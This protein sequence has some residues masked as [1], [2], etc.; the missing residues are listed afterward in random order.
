MDT[1]EV[2]M[3]TLVAMIILLAAHFAAFILNYNILCIG[4]LIGIYYCMYDLASVYHTLKNITYI[5]EHVEDDTEDED[6]AETSDVYEIHS[7]DDDTDD[8]MPPL[9]PIDQ[10][11]RVNSQLQQVVDETNHRNTLRAYN[12]AILGNTSSSDDM[13]KKIKTALIQLQDMI[14][15]AKERSRLRQDEFDELPGLINEFKTD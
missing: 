3:E 12:A 14:T 6:D 9:I 1:A 7:E 11:D 4:T 5:C 8:D 10:T 15:E 2:L 13:S